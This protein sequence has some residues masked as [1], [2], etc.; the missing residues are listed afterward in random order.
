MIDYWRQL[1]LVSPSD[2]DFTVTVIGVGGLGSPIALALAK[3]GCPRI[4]ILDDD[5]VEAHNLPNQLFRLADI[6][7]TKVD[8][9]AENLR[10]YVEADIVSIAERVPSD[11]VFDGIV[12][13]A[14]DSMASR[15]AIW[16]ASVRYRAGVALYVDARLGG[17]V[18]RVLT[19]SPTHPERVRSYEETLYTDDE[20]SED[21]C[22]A[23]AT[24]YTTFGIAALVANQVKRHARG[25]DLTFDQ[26]IDFST[27]TLIAS[28]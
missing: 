15:K 5:R 8:A 16:D 18:G 19:L 20:A 27:T 26:I 21:P 1:D 24:I 2:L 17:E 7:R 9:L 10:E 13:S 11:R 25:E 6:G 28:S 23:Q 4:T 12:V 3:M 22:T 14:V